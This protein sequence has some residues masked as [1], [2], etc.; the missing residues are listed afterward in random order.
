MTDLPYYEESPP[1]R[2]IALPRVPIYALTPQPS[3]SEGT[4]DP[5]SFATKLKDLRLST[6]VAVSFGSSQKGELLQAVNGYARRPRAAVAHS[7][8]I[9]HS[10]NED[11]G[12][13]PEWSAAT[14]L[15]CLDLS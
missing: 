1:A 6:F 9:Q 2:A 4:A 12:R 15:S 5:T 8:R 3:T 14:R 7:S 13:C 10:M 11:M